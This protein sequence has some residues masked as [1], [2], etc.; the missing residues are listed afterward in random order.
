MKK[1]KRISVKVDTRFKGSG[2]TNYLNIKLNDKL[3]IPSKKESSKTS[4][5][6]NEYSPEYKKLM[7]YANAYFDGNVSGAIN[8]ILENA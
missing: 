3:P 4:V 6:F 8:F 2:L 5:A 1:W 7:R